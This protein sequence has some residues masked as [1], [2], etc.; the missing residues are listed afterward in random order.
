MRV[1]SPLPFTLRSSQPAASAAG[2]TSKSCCSGKLPPSGNTSAAGLVGLA[3]AAARG[4]QHDHHE[5]GDREGA[6]D[7]VADQLLALLGLALLALAL[8]A[9]AAQ[10]LLLLSAVR[11]GGE[12]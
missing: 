9:L 7:P 6:A 8:L 2:A 10:R 1:R 4:Q 5:H 11:H 3:A 12:A